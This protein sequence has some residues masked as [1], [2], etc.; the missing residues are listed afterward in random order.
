M[1]QVDFIS[2]NVFSCDVALVS[3]FRI[4]HDLDEKPLKFVFNV[5]LDRKKANCENCEF[6][7]YVTAQNNYNSEA[8]K[9]LFAD[10]QR[11]ESFSP[12]RFINLK[13][14]KDEILPNYFV[15]HGYADSF[16]TAKAEEVF[17]V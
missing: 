1:K 16:I 12:L 14:Y 10:F 6:P 9:Q 15:Y 11:G 13:V 7:V 2:I 17:H 3:T 5:T 8:H 4:L